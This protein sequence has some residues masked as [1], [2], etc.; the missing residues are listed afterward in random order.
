MIDELIKT[1][2]ENNVVLVL[3]ERLMI[4]DPSPESDEGVL[5]SLLTDACQN[6][7]SRYV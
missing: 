5:L 7:E 3:I 2:E 6:F 4:T 1:P